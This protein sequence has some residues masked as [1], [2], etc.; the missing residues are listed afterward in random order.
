MAGYRIAFVLLLVLPLAAAAE[1][2]VVTVAVASNFKVTAAELAVVFEA[3]TGHRVR[4]SAGSTGK[5]Y[6]QIV[7]GAPFD[8]FLAADAERPRLL[9]ESGLGIETSRF[10]YATGS[11]V[12]WFADP[13]TAGRDCRN[14]L[15][16]GLNG[17]LAIANPELAPYGRA[18]RE[19]LVEAGYW[20]LLEDRLAV[21]ESIAQAFQFVATANAEAGLLALSQTTQRTRMAPRG[22]V[23]P[24]PRSMHA[25]I[26]QQAILLDRAAGNPAALALLEF[27][28]N[29]AAREIIAAHGYPPTDEP[30]NGPMNGPM[31]G[32]VNEPANE[33]TNESVDEPTNGSI[34]EQTNEPINEPINELIN[35]L[36]NGLINEPMNEPRDRPVD[37]RID[38]AG[39]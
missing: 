11:L 38:G 28:Q 17:R 19:F 25:P 16:G 4:L 2:R 3:E 24:V 12:L 7:N 31:N 1:P 30:I 27:L 9:A 18:A 33:P 15:E 10:T 39:R 22:C 20:A 35:G 6:A 37:G 8:V 5:L 36:I 14:L 21:G 13:A 26:E 23:W 32:P 34:N 29:K